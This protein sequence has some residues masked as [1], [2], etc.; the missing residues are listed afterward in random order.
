MKLSERELALLAADRAECLQA[1][2]DNCIIKALAA[3]KRAWDRDVHAAAIN[4]LHRRRW[5]KPAKDARLTLTK[6]WKESSCIGRS[7]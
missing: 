2:V 3:D 5:V 6:K 7:A 4:D 1:L